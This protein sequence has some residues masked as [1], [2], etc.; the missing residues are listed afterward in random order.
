VHS[1]FESKVQGLGRANL[2]TEVSYMNG[3]LVRRGTKG[4][5]RLDVVEGDPWS[6]TAVYDLK[7]GTAKLTPQRVQQIQQH[8]PGGSGVPVKELRPQ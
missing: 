2:N 4:S 1:A 5:V 7:T 8:V 3:N 6:P